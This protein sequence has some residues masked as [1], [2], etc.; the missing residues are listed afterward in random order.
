MEGG[1]EVRSAAWPSALGCQG[2]AMITL[3]ARMLLWLSS[4]H[5]FPYSQ[6][7][8]PPQYSNKLLKTNE[9]GYYALC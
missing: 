6:K 1:F 5:F 2:R 9:E 3:S 4:V 7:I 8:L